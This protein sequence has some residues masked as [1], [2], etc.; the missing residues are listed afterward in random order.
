MPTAA[1]LLLLAGAVLT[2]G[3]AALY[4]RRVRMP[5]PAVGR[6]TGSDVAIMTVLLI[7]LPFGYIH[8]PTP[9]LVAVFGVLFLV[10]IQTALAPV[11]GGRTG[12]LVAVAG[13]GLVLA[14]GLTHHAA[15]LM[16]GNDALIVVA[17]TGVVN[18]WVQTGMTAAQVAALSA[19]LALYDL[20]ATG[21]TS[22]T[23]SFFSRI[24]AEAF[25]PALAASHG[26]TPVALG[27]GDCLMLALWPLA[28]TKA[29]GRAAGWIG[30][31]AGLAAVAAVE[32]GSAA[33]WITGNV[34]IL[35]IIGP[36]AVVQWAYWR[37]R[38]GA[39][40]TTGGWQSGAPPGPVRLGWPRRQGVDPALEPVTF[41]ADQVRLAPRGRQQ[42]TRG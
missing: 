39:E 35:T 34:P 24:S 38:I 7:A 18:L 6:F 4:F 17:V 9:V 28:A 11:L 23:A 15:L 3:V 20:V 8:L 26:T 12:L 36:L 13:C 10:V 30:A 41:A 2:T 5:R 27:L 22:F 29:Y 31:V 33:G 19:V 40:R 14:F 25:A 16:W 1:P 21:L 42:R 37:L 32:A